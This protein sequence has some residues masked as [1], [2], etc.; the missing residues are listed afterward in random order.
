MA[1]RPKRAAKTAQEPAVALWPADQVERRDLA[2][3]IPYARNARLHDEA[4]VARLADSIKQWG[5]TIPVLVDEHDEVIA[6]H[7]RIMAAQKIGIE[8]VPVMVARGWSPAQVKAYRLADN[9]LNELSSWD[10]ALLTVE[11]AELNDLGLAALSGFSAI[12]L[13]SLLTSASDPEENWQGMPE[14]A[15]GNAEAYRSMMVHFV[16]E[17][18]VRQFAQLIGQVIRDRQ[19]Y[20]WFPLVP[21]RNEG[22]HRYL[23]PEPDQASSPQ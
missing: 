7:G 14:V 3:L 6:G 22:A 21:R 20:L 18:A 2:S 13:D 16:D 4:Q 19:K 23:S 10:A 9:K 15:Q 8:S 11:L 12:E 17:E 5:W 1:S